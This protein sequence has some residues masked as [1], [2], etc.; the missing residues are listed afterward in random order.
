MWSELLG[1]GLCFLFVASLGVVESLYF[2]GLMNLNYLISAKAVMAFE[3]VLLI[4]LLEGGPLF[5]RSP[6]AL[7]YAY[8]QIL[9]INQ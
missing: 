5:I 9:R 7:E 4:V 1:F 2:M 3:G 8:L 6:S